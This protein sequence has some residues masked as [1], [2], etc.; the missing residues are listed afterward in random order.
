MKATKSMKELE[1]SIPQISETSGTESEID[2]KIEELKEKVKTE[3]EKIITYCSEQSNI[4]KEKLDEYRKEFLKKEYFTKVES[5]T[6]KK[7]WRKLQAEWF[8]LNAK[9][10]KLQL[11]LL[12]TG[13]DEYDLNYTGESEFY[14]IFHEHPDKRRERLEA[15]IQHKIDKIE[16]EIATIDAEQ[17]KLTV[18]SIENNTE[19]I[20]ESFEKIYNK[21]LQII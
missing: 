21:M 12:E 1:I 8:E 2:E 14:Q 16:A 13:C 17:K 11:E 20:Y 10:F 3:F 15:P 18:Y 4:P 5:I 19:K 9:I 7:Q 6:D